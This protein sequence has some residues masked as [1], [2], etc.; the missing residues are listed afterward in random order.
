M[1]VFRYT[2]FLAAGPACKR[3][4][5]ASGSE[6]RMMFRTI[7]AV[8]AHHWPFGLIVEPWADKFTIT[9]GDQLATPGDGLLAEARL[10]KV[11]GSN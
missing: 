3:G 10:R 5:S 11:Q 1:T 2:A 9:V 4:R 7:L 8:T 6:T